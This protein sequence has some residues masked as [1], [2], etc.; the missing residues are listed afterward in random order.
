M[1]RTFFYDL[2]TAQIKLGATR[3]ADIGAAIHARLMADYALSDATGTAILYD[4]IKQRRRQSDMQAKC[5][6]GFT[7]KPDFARICRE[8]ASQGA[9]VGR[10]TMKGE[11][12][13]TLVDMHSTAG[14]N[15]IR[16][17]VH[18]AYVTGTMNRWTVLS[19][20][21]VQA[22]LA[23][24]PVKVEGFAATDMVVPVAP[25]ISAAAPSAAPPAPPVA[26]KTAWVGVP[27]E[28]GRRE[29]L[30]GHLNPVAGEHIPTAGTAWLDR[31]GKVYTVS[32]LSGGR[33]LIGYFCPAPEVAAKISTVNGPRFAIFCR[34][35]ARSGSF[36]ATYPSE[37]AAQVA[38]DGI[39]SYCRQ[40]N[41]Y[42]IRQ[43]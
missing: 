6:W 32:G 37:M 1:T 28:P 41:G 22:V 31:D 11:K 8:L 43:I 40:T 17:N 27:G 3:A 24:A 30:L 13:V 7:A 38:L 14:R 42:F 4:R 35:G 26:P 33:K 2:E 19:G 36:P 20:D 18:H 10:V 16:L 9:A 34:D 21:H 12:P 15:V 23:L 25:G 39:P 29:Y 5:E